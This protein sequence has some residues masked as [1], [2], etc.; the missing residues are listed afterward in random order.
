MRE[1]FIRHVRAALTGLVF[2][3]LLCGVLAGTAVAQRTSPNVWEERTP[4]PATPTP[5]SRPG[6]RPAPRT[7]PPA[8]RNPLLTVKWRLLKFTNDGLRKAVSVDDT[9]TSQDRLLL[10]VNASQNG[11]LYIIRQPAA[12]RDGQLLFPS[13]YYNGGR[14]YVRAD[15]DVVLPSA[16]ADFTVP[17]W[18]SLAPPDG[19]EIIT[20]VLSRS[21]IKE[22][23]NSISPTAAAAPGVSSRVIAQLLA[24]SQQRLQRR[25]GVLD[26]RYTV[27]VENINA[28]NNQEII[29][30]LTLNKAASGNPANAASGAAQK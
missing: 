9:F 28:E 18:F 21:E 25:A 3:F 1:V 6:R 7:T 16:C 11:Y 20:L 12:D 10:E 8:Q 23:P 22:L 17:C 14:N 27:W 4:K 2:V 26:D 30:T 29:E 19:K 5:T 15:Q 24:G 13:R